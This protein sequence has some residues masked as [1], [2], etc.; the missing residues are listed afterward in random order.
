MKK[1][2]ALLITLLILPSC[3]TTSIFKEKIDL[4]QLLK[5]KNK[6][7]SSDNAARQLLLKNDLT[8]KILVL[9]RIKVKD[10]IPSTNVDYDFCVIS[11]IDSPDGK[12]ELYIYTKNIRA[13]SR[14]DKGESVI[15]VE[16]EFSRFF[17][18]LDDYY[19]KIDIINSR[20]KVEKPSTADAE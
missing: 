8:N 19:V 14:L 18:M 3:A 13:L 7:D 16:G 1:L 12:I 17:T 11:D 6:I 2:T 4:N 9:N 5:A 20:I 15:S 10:I